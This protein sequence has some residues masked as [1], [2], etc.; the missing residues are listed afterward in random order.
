MTESCFFY[1]AHRSRTPDQ[2]KEPKVG[3][4]GVVSKEI[5]A[6]LAVGQGRVGVGRLVTRSKSPLLVLGPAP[7]S[8]SHRG[9]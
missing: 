2:H 8:A 7:T 1:V 6:R 9:M 5:R 3:G 4:E